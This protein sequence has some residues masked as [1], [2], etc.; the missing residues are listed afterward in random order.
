[1][2][3][4]TQGAIE[5]VGMLGL[6]SMGGPMAANVARRGF[7]VW[8]YDPR[9]EALEAAAE[10]G[11]RGCASPAEVARAAQVT[12]AIPFDYA[13]VEQAV[14][15]SEGLIEGLPEPGLFVYM[16][17]IGPDNARDLERRLA[18]RGHRLL[19]APVS[20]GAAGAAA[21]TL[22][23]I[24]GGASEDLERCRPVLDAFAANV[25]HVG[26]A[27][28]TGQAAKLVNQLLVV[29]HLAATAEALALGTR[30]GVD[31]QQ[32][33]EMICTAAGNSVIFQSR[34][35]AIL[36]R[37]FKTGGSL[38]ILVKDA[39]LVLRA[40]EPSST[41]LFAAA[42]AGQVFELA[43]AFGLGDQ[44]DAAVAKLYEA[45]GNVEIG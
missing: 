10:S 15:G 28:G 19:D 22:T 6:G 7:E 20:G 34:G 13:Q 45:L 3:H 42:A 27:V 33:Y 2:D 32:L 31:P 12:L 16:S 38:N 37:G 39:R 36:D 23:V 8:A 43:R 30:S 35:K 11:I 9:P 1:M 17:T 44:D 18:E 40:G 29:T 14:F 21:G 26:P 5:R 25:F 41:P 4:S 24:V